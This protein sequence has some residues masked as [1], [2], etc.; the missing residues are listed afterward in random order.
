M[1]RQ[2]HSSRQQTV[3]Q[4]ITVLRSLQSQLT[5]RCLVLMDPTVQPLTSESKMTAHPASLESTA[6]EARRVLLLTSRLEIAVLALTAQSDRKSKT[7]LLWM[8]M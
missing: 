1:I 6:C 2:L 4:A 5:P 3:T 8:C 7:Q